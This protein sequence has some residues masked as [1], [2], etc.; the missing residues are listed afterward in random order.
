[1]PNSIFC[2]LYSFFRESSLT[3]SLSIHMNACIYILSLFI[4]IFTCGL[5]TFPLPRVQVGIY[6]IPKFPTLDTFLLDLTTQAAFSLSVSNFPSSGISLCSADF[7]R[8]ILSQTR[9]YSA[10]SILQPSSVILTFSSQVEL[11]FLWLISLTKGQKP[12]KLILFFKVGV[13]KLK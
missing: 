2:I 9:F 11:A 7:L 5:W 3:L 4:L 13:R 8:G 6:V 12:N 10:T 1:M